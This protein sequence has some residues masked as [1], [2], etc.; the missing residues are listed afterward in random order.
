MDK[1]EKTVTGFVVALIV[2]FF[3]IIV[4]SIITCGFEEENTVIRSSNIVKYELKDNNMLCITTEND[5]YN[6][7]IYDVDN[8]D[9]TI[10]SELYLELYRTDRSFWFWEE[11][12]FEG[13][14]YIDRIVKLPSDNN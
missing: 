7:D 3:G 9:L 14:Y 6:I 11:P 1:Y 10:N 2:I 5:I 12:L 8:L 13:N 4:M